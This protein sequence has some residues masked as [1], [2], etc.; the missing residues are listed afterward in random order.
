ML[1]NLLYL[2][3][4]E[5]FLTNLRLIGIMKIINTLKKVDLELVI[6]L[7]ALVV[8]ALSNPVYHHITLCPL[9]NL[10]FKYCPGCGLGRSISYLF[11]GDI[12]ASFRMHPLG[13]FALGI[14]G[15][16]IIQII[17]KQYIHKPTLN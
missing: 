11:R 4:N 12:N 10:G 8:L 15:Y 7:T 1:F 3:N 16:R 2:N 9:D 14:I 17:N 13:I 6:W 5:T